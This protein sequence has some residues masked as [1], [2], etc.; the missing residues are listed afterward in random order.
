MTHSPSQPGGRRPP[1]VCGEIL[2]RATIL[3]TRA[4]MQNGKEVIKVKIQ[5]EIEV[6]AETLDE[7]L[8]QLNDLFKVVR[9]SHKI[10]K[11]VDEEEKVEE[12][13]A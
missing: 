8:E 3:I 5:C 6:T 12:D 4:A 11:K 2:A 9:T 7:T 1:E 13:A 10:V